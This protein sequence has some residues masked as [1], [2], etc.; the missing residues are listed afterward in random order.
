MGIRKFKDRK[1]ALPFK[2]VGAELQFYER[3]SEDDETTKVINEEGKEED[4]IILFAYKEY[5]LPWRLEFGQGAE[6][7]ENGDPTKQ[8]YVTENYVSLLAEAKQI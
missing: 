5:K 3:F 4:K 2:W 7:D 1:P 6:Y 8:D